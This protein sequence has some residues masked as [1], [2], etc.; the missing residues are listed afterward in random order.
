M[1]LIFKSTTTICDKNDRK[2]FKYPLNTLLDR[3]F[4]DLWKEIIKYLCSQPFILGFTNGTYPFYRIMEE[5]EFESYKVQ[6]F[7]YYFENNGI[8]NVYNICIKLNSIVTV[9]QSQIKNNN[10]PL[11]CYHNKNNNSLIEISNNYSSLCLIKPLNMANVLILEDGKIMCDC[12][13]FLNI[14]IPDIKI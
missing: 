11:L 7:N 4:H 14:F 12:C 8:P 10:Y 13:P 5:T 3:I 6:F 2:L 9:N 1:N